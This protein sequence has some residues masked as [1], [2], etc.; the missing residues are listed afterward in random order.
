M[1]VANWEDKAS[2]IRAIQKCL[3]IGMDSLVFLDDNPFERNLVRSMIPEITVPEL[4]E[5]PAMYLTYLRSLGL[6]EMASYSADDSGRTKQYREQA[7]RAVFASSFQS[8]DDYLEGLAMVAVAAPFDSFHYPR[9]AQLT[10]RSNQFNLR[11]V[12][13]TEAEVEAVAQDENRI[14]LYFML[15][16]KFGDHGLISVV[17]L[18]KQEDS[19]L[20]VSQWLM[21]C[22][23]LK[24]GM[25]E[26]IVNKMIRT[27]AELG[28]GKVIGEYIPTAKNAMVQD[29]YEKLGFVR[30][31]ENRFEADVAGFQY[32]K[33]FITEE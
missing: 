33:T 9:I 20:F 13:Y 19:T 8:Y 3:N 28:Y 2:N 14:G 4:P 30:V 10:Q 21:S 23:V 26:F 16:D 5:D 11:T 27:A 25:E 22:R 17:V 29:L 32:H 7:E 12:R 24:R 18:D 6:F 1:F 31:D 15:K